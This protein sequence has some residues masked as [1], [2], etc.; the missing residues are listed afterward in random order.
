MTVTSCEGKTMVIG[1]GR[2]VQPSTESIGDVRLG[3]PCWIGPGARLCGDHGTIV[4]G[5][6]CAVEDAARARR[7]GSAAF[8]QT[9]SRRPHRL[10]IAYEA[11]C[12]KRLRLTE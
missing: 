5:E 11:Y 9:R 10:S 2:W 4:L 7:P 3:A 8:A 6:G 1:E 12:V